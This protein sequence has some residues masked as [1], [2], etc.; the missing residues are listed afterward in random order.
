[1]NVDNTRVEMYL[2]C[3]GAG[4]IDEGMMMREYWFDG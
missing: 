1:M 3:A 4:V 2:M